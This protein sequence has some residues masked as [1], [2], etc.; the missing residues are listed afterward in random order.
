M[1]LLVPFASDS[2]LPMVIASIK[3]AAALSVVMLVLPSCMVR[4]LPV[5]VSRKIRGTR[6]KNVIEIVVL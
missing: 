5:D 3:G 4:P 1:T 6:E 2:P